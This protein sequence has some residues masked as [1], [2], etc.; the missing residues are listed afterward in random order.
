MREPDHDTAQGAPPGPSVGWARDWVE[1]W[2]RQQEEALPDRED[3]FTAL[4]DAVEEGTGR[5]EPLV[6]DVGCGPGSLAVRLLDRLPRATVIGI[7]ADPVALALG[8]AAYPALAGLRFIDLDLREPGWSRRLDLARHA[9]AAVSTTAL[10]WLPE[11]HLRAMYAELATVLR[12]GGLLLNGDHFAV[13]AKEAPTLARLHL[14][15]RQRED[16][17]RFPQGHPESWRAWWEAAAADPLLARYVAERNRR[18]VEAGH[19]GTGSGLLATHVE[20]LRAAGFAEIG[21]LWQRGDNHLLCA[22]LPGG[23]AGPERGPDGVSH[24]RAS[25]KTATVSHKI[26]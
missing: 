17:R 25:S 9:D 5:Q 20:A 26:T 8:R 18:D 2:D 3:R 1:R 23:P 7:D 16:R 6:L 14:A 22:V 11:P 21:T 10:H 13:D 4:I 24:S 15:L 19:H 12:P